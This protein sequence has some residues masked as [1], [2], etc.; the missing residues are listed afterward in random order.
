MSINTHVLLASKDIRPY[1]KQL[2]SISESAVLSVKKLLP[3]NDVDVVFYYNPGATFNESEVGGIGGFTPN[4]SVIFISLNPRH[5]NLESS[6]KNELLFMLAHE[7]HHTIRWQKQVEGDTLLEAL[8]F[9]GLADHF[10][11]EITGKKTPSIYSNALTPEQKK[12]FL[13]KAS[14]EWEKPTYDNNL[15][16]FGS[17]PDVVP[18]WTGY[19]LGYDLVSAYLHT[20]PGTS[21]SKLASADASL[22]ANK[23]IYQ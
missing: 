9:E 15:W 17:Q 16:F 5:P 22:F 18:R 14:G 19:T 21:A 2:K 23:S 13:K 1:V 3:I 7:F 11:Q 8:V 10:A 6:L 4:A 20:N 12:I